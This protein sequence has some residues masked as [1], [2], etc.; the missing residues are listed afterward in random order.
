MKSDKGAEA[1]VRY[2]FDQVN[3]AWTTPDPDPIDTN[4]EEGC[5]SCTSLSDTAKQLRAK[6]HRYASNPVTVSNTKLVAGAP[7]GQQFVETNLLQHRVDVVDASGNVVST[8]KRATLLRTVAVIWRG[9]RWL[10][11]GVA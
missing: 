1:F 2:F 3:L 11:Y 4:S 6:G 8:D 7:K 10:I 9:D 5:K